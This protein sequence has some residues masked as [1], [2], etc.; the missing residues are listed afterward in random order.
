MSYCFTSTLAAAHPDLSSPCLALYLLA[1]LDPAKANTGRFFLD[2]KELPNKQVR[3]RMHAC[4]RVVCLL[5]RVAVVT[6]SG[7]VKFYFL[8]MHH[9]KVCGVHSAGYFNG[10]SVA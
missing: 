6:I 9:I 3:A 5:V 7:R 4:V 2:V 8:Q 10:T 1:S